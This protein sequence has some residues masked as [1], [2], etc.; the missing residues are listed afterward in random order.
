MA[1]VVSLHMRSE[2]L[3]EASPLEKARD[4]SQSGSEWQVPAMCVPITAAVTL[5]DRAMAAHQR[6]C[7]MHGAPHP[8]IRPSQSF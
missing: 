5:D 3:K 4:V 2:W 1:T 7:L 6:H 8:V